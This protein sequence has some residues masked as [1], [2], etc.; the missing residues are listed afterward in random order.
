METKKNY[1]QKTLKFFFFLV[2]LISC[3]EKPLIADILIINGKV[4]DGISNNPSN[5]TIAIKDDKIIYIGSDS[6]TINASKVIDAKGLI[7]SSGFIDPH[8]HADGDLSNP[9]QSHNLPF[10][11]QGV[12]T[13]VTG[14]DGNSLYPTSDYVTLYKSHGIGTNVVP[15]IGHGT[16]RKQVMGTSDKKATLDEIS[17]MQSLIQQEMDAG[18]FG[19]STGLFYSPGSYSNTEEV[20]ALA[21]IVSQNDGV[22]DTHLRDESSYTVGLI[23]AIEEAIEIG[24]QAELPI[25]LSHIKCLGVDVWNQ[26]DSIISIVENAQKEGINVTANQYPYNASS[27]S[28]KAATVPRWA[29][30]G[31]LDSLFIRYNNLELKTKILNETKRNI[32]RRG[33]PEK[34]LISEADDTSLVGL[35]LMEVSKNYNLSAE[36]SVYKALSTGFVKV[37]SF[38]MNDY[39]IA[40]FMKQ[41]WVVTGSDGGSGHPR[42]YGSF[43]KKYAY[44][45]QKEN[46]IGLARFINNST[47]KTAEILKISKRGKLQVGYYADIIIFNPEEF[48]DLADYNDAFKFAEGIEYSIINGKLS[49]YNGDFTNSLNGKV[50]VK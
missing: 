23:P 9:D 31:G 26:S 15:L 19:M 49:I 25:H 22:Y 39:D 33:G 48:K 11:M 14:N 1:I 6:S 37:V 35:N 38:N 17:K 46:V 16:V 41:S 21:K 13:V 24:R 34:L 44:Y 18:A 28:L 27:T 5:T 10:L 42:K 2:I 7:V 45:V 30:S 29:E 43:P 32:T 40:N 47:S 36:Q 50:L 12:T 8:T 20:I 3:N 4:Y